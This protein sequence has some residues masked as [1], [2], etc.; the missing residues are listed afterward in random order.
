M[1]KN[2]RCVF[3]HKEKVNN[4]DITC[5]Q[6][7]VESLKN[8]V[9]EINTKIKSLE[10]ELIYQKTPAAKTNIDASEEYK[11][12]NWSYVCK[13]EQIFRRTKEAIGGDTA[14]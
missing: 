14:L 5:L 10:Q 13:R 12:N 4:N 8:T 2:R 3:I 1:Q 11:C 9:S 6:A 7:Q